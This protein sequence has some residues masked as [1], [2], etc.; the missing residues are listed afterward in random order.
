M[1]KIY[2]ISKT[3]LSLSTYLKSYLGHQYSILFLMIQSCTLMSNRSCG[4]GNLGGWC[5]DDHWS[6]QREWYLDSILLAQPKILQ[7]Y[8]F[9]GRTQ[10]YYFYFFNN[11][12]TFSKKTKLNVFFN[13]FCLI[14]S[15]QQVG[16]CCPDPCA[17]AWALTKLLE[18]LGWL[19]V[20]VSYP[21]Q[22]ESCFKSF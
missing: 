20:W 21:R 17:C 19:A 4:S 8:C 10:N 11:T 16:D 1:N 15:H 7:L 18:Y 9:V 3:H 12:W 22:L 13:H 2:T 6:N 5:I 14:Y